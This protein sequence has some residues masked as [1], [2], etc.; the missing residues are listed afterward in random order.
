MTT[1]KIKRPQ[2]GHRHPEAQKVANIL[3]QEETVRLNVNVP[4]SFHKK[5]RRWALEHDITVTQM[6]IEALEE[7]MNKNS[8][9]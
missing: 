7:H 6:V 3:G 5:V 2:K 9:E 1:L 8:D 4:K